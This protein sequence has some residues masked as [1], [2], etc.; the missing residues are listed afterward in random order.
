[1]TSWR[2]FL[3]FILATCLLLVEGVSQASGPPRKALPKV[4]AEDLR[5]APSHSYLV[6]TF[7]PGRLSEL[8]GIPGLPG[9]DL[10]GS[11]PFRP[12]EIERIGAFVYPDASS[13][14]LA[15]GFSIQ[16]R[17]DLPRKEVVDWLNPDATPESPDSRVYLDPEWREDRLSVAFPD[18]RTVLFSRDRK[19]V[20]EYVKRSGA[21]SV[22]PPA[23]LAGAFAGLDKAAQAYAVVDGNRLKHFLQLATTNGL[24]PPAESLVAACPVGLMRASWDLQRPD[25]LTI[26]HART[27]TGGEGENAAD[28]F[29]RAVAA[30][31][32]RLLRTTDHLL[33]ER[34]DDRVAS[35]GD[36]LD[37]LFSNLK[38]LQDNAPESVVQSQDLPDASECVSLVVDFMQL[39]V[40]GLQQQ[41]QNLRFV[42]RLSQVQLGVLGYHTV[43]GSY[44]RDIVSEDGVPLLSWRVLILPWLEETALRESFRVDEPWDSNHNRALINRMPEAFAPR[45]QRVADKTSI[46]LATGE[47][48][49][50][51]GN[52]SDTIEAPS[53]TLSIV[54]SEEL[55]EWSRPGDFVFNTA[56]PASGL[57]PTGSFGKLYDF[58][59]VFLPPGSDAASLRSLFL[60]SREEFDVG[61]FLRGG[62]LL[63]PEAAYAEPE[64]LGD[65]QLGD[66]IRRLS[67][68]D[69]ADVN[70]ALEELGKH[71]RRAPNR[72]S[73]LVPEKC[74]PLLRAASPLTRGLA[75]RALAACRA[76]EPV[77]WNEVAVL[78]EDSYEMNRWLALDLLEDF[79]RVELVPRL[80]SL[81][82][83]DVPRAL[84][85]LRSSFAGVAAEGVLPLLKEE[86][87]HA[88]MAACF[89]IGSIGRREHAAD[90]EPLLEDR[91]AACQRIAKLVIETLNRPGMFEAAVQRWDGDADRAFQQLLGNAET[92]ESGRTV[93]VDFDSSGAARLLRP[94]DY[95]ALAKL[96]TLRSLALTNTY[97]MARDVESLRRLPLKELRLNYCVRIDDS[98]ADAI[99]SFGNLVVLR[100]DMSRVGD[101]TA[102]AIGQLESLQELNLSGTQITEAGI[103]QLGNLKQLE[104]LNLSETAV[105][106]ASLTLLKGLPRLR[107]LYL[108]NTGL[109]DAAVDHLATLENLEFVNL[110]RSRVSE[111]GLARLQAALPQCRVVTP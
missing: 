41:M 103:E 92:D 20:S 107:R 15:F 84:E 38:P 65:E 67:G 29:R 66:L 96:T 75:L 51:A 57:R 48:T 27:P 37:S 111:K 85:M 89:V 83:T 78:L 34:F 7:R 13:Q 97:V 11:I 104:S 100:L 81:P 33:D 50:G 44:P 21:A 31:L 55:I 86:D 76:G 18:Q 22:Q 58:R 42:N 74:T 35:V 79:P 110:S 28:S 88:R 105:T 14:S 102:R 43:Y 6:G 45:R 25:G 17:I 54:E 60:N 71:T 8:E 108:L 70:R 73:R 47:G 91:N 49:G 99:G 39:Q 69:L 95:P 82:E 64:P 26:V 80:L 63:S 12:N 16:L 3:G 94:G 2:V 109:T 9:T 56:D 40:R 77:D 87:E 106:D 53:H 36:R 24:D 46:R 62:G 90:L 72:L 32:R 59:S 10:V 4:L 19:Y 5:Y 101:E 61:P 68:A 1:M 23:R 52:G 30:Y 98:V 93:A